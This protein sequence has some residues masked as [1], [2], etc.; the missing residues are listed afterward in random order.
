MNR[1]KAIGALLKKERESLN[2]SL[3]YVTEKMGFQHHQILS[4]IEKGTREIKAWELVKLVEIYGR[5][6]DF[7]LSGQQEVTQTSRVLWREPERTSETI[8][9]ERKLLLFCENYKKLL[10]LTGENY[11]KTTFSPMSTVTKEN[12]KNGKFD[13]V[14]ELAERYRNQLNLG[15]RPSYS[16][17]S[18]LEGNLGVLVLYLD[19]NGGSAA[20]TSGSVCNAILMNSRNAPW[21]QNYDLAH[22][23]FH[24][25]TWDVFSDEEIYS[26]PKSG[27]KNEVEQWAEAFAS[28]LLLPAEE[29]RRKFSRRVKGREITYMSLIE[30]AR[31]FR[32]SIEA[33]LWRLTNLNLLNRKDVLKCLKEGNI[34]DIDKEMRITDW[35][36]KQYLSERYI[37]LAIKA[38]HIG[39]ITRARFA[40]YVDIAFSE[41][42]SFLKKYGY[43]E[44]EDYTIAFS[45]T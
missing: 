18:V 9:A 36:E 45:A 24:L 37:T 44:N 38:L 23:L 8:Q 3:K 32:V 19:L 17:C 4:K 22:E 42:P 33:L 7:F 10:E 16:L 14:V 2:Y 11:T 41:V 31:E 40:E 5:K 1:T 30:I 29:V 13:F 15:G 43:S 25:I 28:A 35:G 34:K 21:R 6:I 26:K 20:S 12:F 27:N 39:K